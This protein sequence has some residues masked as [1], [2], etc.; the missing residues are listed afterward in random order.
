[1]WKNS[2]NRIASVIAVM[3]IF[4]INNFPM[5]LSEGPYQLNWW[6]FAISILCAFATIFLLSKLTYDS[7]P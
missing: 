5:F 4:L 6:L 2:R 3:E 7:E 1:M